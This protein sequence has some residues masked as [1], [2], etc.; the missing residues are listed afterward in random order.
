MLGLKK[1]YDWVLSL[2][3]KKR[4]PY[5]LGLISVAEA[6]IFPLPPDV[7]LIAL[8]LGNRLKSFKFAIIC[9]LGSIIGASIGYYIGM[10]L[11]WD[12]ADGISY[13]ASLFY[14]YVPGVSLESFKKVQDLYNEYSF[15][16][17]FTAGFTPVPFKLFTISAGAFK[18]DFIMFILASS[19]SRGLRFF[20]VSSLIYKFGHP[21]KSFIDK[22]FNLLAIV[23]T[24]L[25]MSGFILIK[26]VL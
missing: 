2:S 16:I 21:I 3:E 19:V 23:F 15:W 6:S 4:G 17:V 12:A 18:I 10:V 26:V 22:Y 11:W 7:L 14:D 9:T 8:S 1:T 5:F 13:F 25:L 24:L 20:I